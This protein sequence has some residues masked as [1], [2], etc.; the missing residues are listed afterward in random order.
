MFQTSIKVKVL[1]FQNLQGFASQNKLIVANGQKLEAAYPL[2]IV[3]IARVISIDYDN[4][5]V[6]VANKTDST[7]SLYAS[8]NPVVWGVMGLSS[9]QNLF[10]LRMI[11]ISKR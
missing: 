3:F 9:V 1:P 10:S 4:L 5:R 6:E 8:L 7:D 11:R 2:G